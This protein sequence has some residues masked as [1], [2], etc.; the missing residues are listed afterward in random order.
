[1]TREHAR[2]GR[3]NLAKAGT[4][5]HSQTTQ[6]VGLMP[7]HICTCALEQWGSRPALFSVESCSSTERNNSPPAQDKLPRFGTFSGPPHHSGPKRLFID[8]G[9]QAVKQPTSLKQHEDPNKGCEIP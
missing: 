7:V 8:L 1:M 3:A 4:R 2:I 9:A 6:I 5:L